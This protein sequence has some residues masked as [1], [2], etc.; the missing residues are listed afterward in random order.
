MMSLNS[1]VLLAATAVLIIFLGATGAVLDGAFRTSAEAAEHDR[2]QTQV[3]ALLA[4]AEVQDD[5]SLR[6]PRALAEPRFTTPGSGLYA[7][8]VDAHGNSVWRSPSTVG[9]EVPFTS[10]AAAGKFH[11]QRMPAKGYFAM[12]LEV[13][14]ESGRGTPTRY[15]FQVSENDASYRDQVGSFRRHLWGWLA[16]VAA[17]LLLVQGLILRWGLAPLR[18]VADDLEQVRSGS[19]ANLGGA[20]PKEL[21][22]LTGSINTFIASE[23]AQ[24]D[25][26]RNSLSDLAHSLKTPLAVLRGALPENAGEAGA[27][28]EQVDRIAQIV[29]YQLQRAATSGKPALATPV[30]LRRSVERLTSSLTKVYA[31]RG[32]VIE[33][34]IPDGLTFLGDEGDLLEV[35]G[36]VLDNACKWARARVHIAAARRDESLVVTVDD[37]GPGIA[38]ERRDDVLRR[39]VRADEQVAGH[40]IGL[41]VVR[42]VLAAYGG[43]LEIGR[44]DGLGGARVVLILPAS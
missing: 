5:G 4:A 17:L 22:G 20:Y 6:L 32:V 43:R 10:A 41:A 24:R 19:A 21:E 12:A 16:G 29:D 26:Y 9:V 38:E 25:R 34:D 42:D 35:L 18:R 36:N 15:V 7:R 40:G 31:A 28:D 11:F 30:A 39:G 14:W 33:T 27:V 1:R 37:D 13:V 3:Y 44:A 2:L 23:R 8:I